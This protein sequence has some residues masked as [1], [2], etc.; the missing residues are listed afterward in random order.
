[1]PCSASGASSDSGAPS[2]PTAI[3]A[4]NEVYVA[5]RRA[6]TLGCSS[7]QVLR[8]VHKAQQAATSDGIYAKAKCEGLIRG[9]Y[10]GPPEFSLPG[11]RPKEQATQGPPAPPAPPSLAPAP[12]PPPHPRCSGVDVKIEPADETAQR[13]PTLTPA[14]RMMPV[15]SKGSATAF[16]MPPPPAPQTNARVVLAPA[17]PR[18]GTPSP[19]RSVSASQRASSSG[20]GGSPPWR[21]LRRPRET[22]TTG[23]KRRRAHRAGRKRKRRRSGS[24]SRLR[25]VSRHPRSRTPR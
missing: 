25:T 6:F 2:V 17:G 20:R 16:V 19:S 1:M 14:H 4:V 5:A 8:T 21:N 9:L 23:A 12:P 10:T 15:Q 7:D 18:H 22:G 11:P 24:A 13:L 3:V